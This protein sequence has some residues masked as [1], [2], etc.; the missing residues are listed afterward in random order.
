MNGAEGEAF[1]VTGIYRSPNFGTPLSF[2]DICDEYIKLHCMLHT[3][4]IIGDV[5]IDISKKA[6][7]LINKESY[8]NMLTSNG[9]KALFDKFTS[10]VTQTVV[11][12]TY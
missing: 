10:M 5:N 12:I 7:N 9:F 3:E 2:I 6:Q 11:L 8:L 4:I 1:G